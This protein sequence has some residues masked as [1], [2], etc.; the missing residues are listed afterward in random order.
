MS[1][2]P[3][4]YSR[5]TSRAPPNRSPSMNSAMR[6][7]AFAKINLS[8]R[9]LGTRDDGYHELRTIFQSIALHD[10]LTIRPTRGGFELTCDDPLCPIDGTNLVARAAARMWTAAGRRGAPRGIAIDLRKR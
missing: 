7:R 10:T 2:S 5:S 1:R 6:V 9:V 8:L 3:K 4:Q